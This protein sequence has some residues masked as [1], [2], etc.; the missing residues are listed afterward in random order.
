MFY[1]ENVHWSE[2]NKNNI[3]QVAICGYDTL[4]DIWPS[5]PCSNHHNCPNEDLFFLRPNYWSQITE[6]FYIKWSKVKMDLIIIVK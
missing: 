4:Y 6:K 1:D 2:S 3:I 5:E